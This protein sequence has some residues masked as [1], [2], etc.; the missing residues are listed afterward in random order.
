MGDLVEF[1]CL[2]VYFI[3]LDGLDFSY[4]VLGRVMSFEYSLGLLGLSFGGWQYSKGIKFGFGFY[5]GV[6]WSG[7]ELWRIFQ[8]GVLVGVGFLK[9]GFK[10]V[11]FF[12][13]RCGCCCL[14]LESQVFIVIGYL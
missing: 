10:V 6:F 2:K 3:L 12:W 1:F 11:D 7:F 13:F 14:V 5:V 9:Q 8:E 4:S